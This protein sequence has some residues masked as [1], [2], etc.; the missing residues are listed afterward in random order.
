MVDPRHPRASVD[1]P[2]PPTG[3]GSGP[4]P[5]T[6]AG[7]GLR[8]LLPFLALLAL[9]ACSGSS[10]GTGATASGEGASSETM[11]RPP[12]VVA[13][14]LD[15]PWEIRFLP[16]GDLLVTERPGRLVRL[17]PDGRRVRTDTVPGVA[18]V[19]ESGLMGLALDPSYEDGGDVYLCYTT[20]AGDEG[21][22]N[23]I[24]R[25]RYGAGGL[26]APEPVLREIAG[27]RFHDGCRL[28]FGPDGHLFVTMGDAGDGDRAQDPSSLSGTVLRIRPDGSPAPGNPFDNPVF[29]YGHRNPQGLARDDAGRLW[30]TEHGRS[31]LRSGLDEINL[32][33]RG[34]N[35]GWPEIEGDETAP[36]MVGPVAHSGPDVTWAPAGAAW[37]DESLFFGGLRGEALYEARIPSDA[38]QPTSDRPLD[39]DVVPHF[40]GEY[41]R[42]RVVRGGPDGDEL[43]FATSN[44]DGRGSVREGDDRI[45]AVARDE[46]R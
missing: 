20:E 36:D 30:S 41:G 45:L 21:L 43:Y 17:T 27:A 26:S 1:G 46:L 29:T 39:V 9:G 22:T 42:I 44:T 31:G 28:E 12:R 16:D 23:R 24:D 25:F 40:S 4:E 34:N 2:V 35:Y 14:E 11:D 15:V 5:A 33:V 18:A 32:L 10:G 37:M 7:A 13:T 3:S 19:G 8:G 38:I 6:P